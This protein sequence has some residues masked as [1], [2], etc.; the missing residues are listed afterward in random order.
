MDWIKRLFGRR[1]KLHTLSA[2]EL[3]TLSQRLGVDQDAI[4]EYRREI[5]REIELRVNQ[6][7]D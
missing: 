4:K 3:T 7:A 6:K 2:A 5:A 1:P